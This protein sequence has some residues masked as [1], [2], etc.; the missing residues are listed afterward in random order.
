M[1][2]IHSHRNCHSAYADGQRSASRRA[3]WTSVDGTYIFRKVEC[4]NSSG[5]PRLA[6]V[7]CAVRYTFLVRQGTKWLLPDAAFDDHCPEGT[8]CMSLKLPNI[9]YGGFIE[10]VVCADD[11]DITQEIVTAEAY[12]TV[13]YTHENVHCGVSL[14]LPANRYHSASSQPID[15]VLTEEVRTMDGSPYKVSALSIRDT[16]DP[17]RKFDRVYR[18]GASVASTLIEIPVYRGRLQQRTY[19][20]C[21]KMTP[22]HV[23]KSII[24]AYSFMQV[25]HDFGRVPLE[26]D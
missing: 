11:E 5:D 4:D 2:Q 1:L 22:G 10:E 19:E 17:S 9:L 14:Q 18:Q 23:A 24:F 12:H 8:K 21:M 6:K 3:E 13:Q 25:P 26:I 15:V 7:T 16:P 20:F